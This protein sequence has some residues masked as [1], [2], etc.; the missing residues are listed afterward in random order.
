MRQE[1]NIYI[2][3]VFS[4]WRTEKCSNG[5]S[6]EV[7][8]GGL[9]LPEPREACDYLHQ[10]H[11]HRELSFH[12]LLQAGRG[13]Q[14]SHGGVC[15][16]KGKSLHG[17]VRSHERSAILLEGLDLRGTCPA[18]A[19]IQDPRRGRRLPYLGCIRVAQEV[20]NHVHPKPI[21][22]PEEKP[23]GKLITLKMFKNNICKT[24]T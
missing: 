2:T 12:L 1:N 16:G 9:Q 22:A 10:G 7:L 6:D 3:I 15:G 13:T 20:Q 8:A 18:P 21:A 4:D 19:S 23:I 17:G 24:S 14:P 11:V 5:C